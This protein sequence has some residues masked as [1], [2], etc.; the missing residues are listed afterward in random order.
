VSTPLPSASI[1][2]FPASMPTLHAALL[3]AP[4]FSYFFSYVFLNTTVILDINILCFKH[5]KLK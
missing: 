1:P 4:F 2:P 5:M 3:A